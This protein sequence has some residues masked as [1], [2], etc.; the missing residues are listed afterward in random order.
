[1][2]AKQ[3]IIQ[4]NIKITKFGG[5][6]MK[7]DEF[8]P[9]QLFPGFFSLPNM[10]DNLKEAFLAYILR[11]KVVGQSSPIPSP[12][13]LQGLMLRWMRRIHLVLHFNFCLRRW[14]RRI[15]LVLYFSASHAMVD[16]THPASLL[17]PSFAR[18]GGRDGPTSLLRLHAG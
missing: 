9:S 4:R 11:T 6:K 1:M 3:Q 2:V 12:I 17:L 7:L 15:H 18:D 10:F 14:M 8:R 13:R 16:A 5:R